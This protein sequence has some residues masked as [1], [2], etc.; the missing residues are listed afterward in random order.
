VVIVGGGASGTLV[1]VQLLRNARVPLNIHLIEGVAQEHGLGVAYSTQD[2]FHALNVPVEK[3]SALPDDP[4]H[5]LG[6]AQERDPSVVPGQFLPRRL[7]GEYLQ[8]LLHQAEAGKSPD[9][10]FF[11][12]NDTAVALENGGENPRVRLGS[13][14]DIPT[15]QLVLAFG[16]ARPANIPLEDPSF[17]SSP[18]YSQDPFFR[19]GAAYLNAK[20][21]VLIVGSG[22]TMV[23]IALSLYAKGH[24]GP[25]YAVSRNG[26]L[27][28]V[29]APAPAYT[30]PEDVAQTYRGRDLEGLREALAGEIAKANAT[31]SN[32]RA[33]IDAL[34]PL[35]NELWAGL[36]EQDQAE[37]LAKYSRQWDIHRHRIP[38]TSAARIQELVSAGRLKII[39]GRIDALREVADGVTATVQPP[40]GEE[41]VS[42]S[43]AHVVNATGPNT[44]YLQLRETNP[45]VGSLLDQGLIQPDHLRLGLQ[46]NER[47]ALVGASGVASDFISTLG[48]PRK[49]RLFWETTAIP[50]IRKQAADLAGELL[51]RF[52]NP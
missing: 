9:L 29:H 52:D 20:G 11:R 21:P 13:G 24:E 51:Q 42:L 3:I 26:I 31:G 49:G 39:A 27:P 1:A 41:A 35:T 37:F 5:F 7:Y 18:R 36:S 15:D 48:P 46:V 44:N 14:V 23:D 17:F 10:N 4:Q 8:D 34:R 25:I 28:Q 38:P 12:V 2:P 45:L 6:W 30:T 33:A 16:N 43:V 32:W 40:D 19:G 50:E 22:L 47:G